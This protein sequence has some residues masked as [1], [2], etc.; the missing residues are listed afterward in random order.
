MIRS[1]LSC[2]LLLGGLPLLG[3]GCGYPSWGL[4]GIS[5]MTTPADP[6]PVFADVQALASP[7]LEAARAD[8]AF[9]AGASA[10]DTL[11]VTADALAGIP[12]RHVI[13]VMRENRSFDHLLG[14]L[15]LEGRPEI[16]GIPSSYTNV[17]GHG[18]RVGFHHAATTCI[19]NQPA[20]QWDAMHLGVDGGRMDGFAQSAAASTG[21]SG[22]FV[23]THY[24][25]ADLPFYHFLASTYA[26][27]DRH[28]AAA[29]SGTYPNRDFLLFG[30]NAGVKETSSA[31]PDPATPSIMRALMNAGHT[32]GAYTDGHPFDNALRWPAG[33][34]G[35]HSL[36]ELFRAADEGELPNVAFVDGIGSHDDDHAPADLQVGEAWLHRLYLHVVHSPQWPRTAMIWTYDEAGGFADHVPP[37][38]GCIPSDDAAE[39]AYF[40]RGPRDPLVAISPYARRGFVSHVVED[41][42]AITRFIEAL[43]GLPSLTRR[44]ANS[45]A[46]LELFDFS[47]AHPAPP[48]PEPGTGGCH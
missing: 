35:V 12:V 3:A 42:T 41:H 6:A 17:D 33:A 34:P 4:D 13:V 1:T 9:G 5:T 10:A 8:C 36:D 48:T 7:Q 45:P 19:G 39:Q 21:T 24:T 30:T 25:R 22:D 32:W 38:N 40:E 27:S 47:A 44:D 37:P 15:R 16:D 14:A 28:F 23:L 18:R 2:K 46:L 26:I 29:C 20:H 43:F 31:T 11:G